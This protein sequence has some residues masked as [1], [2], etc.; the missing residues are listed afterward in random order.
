MHR[1]WE[2]VIK[3]V[4]IATRP[5]T[6][7]EIGSFTGYTT[8]KLL[9]YCK[10]IGGRC[11]VVDPSPQYDAALLC[12]HYGDVVNLITKFSLEVLPSIDQYD[13]ILIDGDH[14]WYTVYHELKQVEQMAGKTGRFPVVLLHDTD[15]PYGYRDMYYF[16]ESIPEEFRKPYA[17]KGMKPGQSELLDNGGFNH[18]AYNAVYEGGQRNGVRS[19]V[20][21]F[22][23]ESSIKLKHYELFSN[24]GLMILIPEE[25]DPLIHAQIT[26][27]L[28]SSGL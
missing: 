26:Y 10:H 17:A 14:N 6:I 1:F 13:M 11:F 22:M 3:H 15:W 4:L 23:K 18:I 9:Q 2:R 25:E 16:P 24:N 8:F 27:I 7:V 12:K 19:A 21:D 5:K 28:D 20:K